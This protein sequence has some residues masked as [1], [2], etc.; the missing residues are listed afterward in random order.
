MI[1]V[2][3]DYKKLLIESLSLG[4]TLVT[5]IT[6]DGS[7]TSSSTSLAVLSPFFRDLVLSASDHSQPLVILDEFSS[8]SVELLMELLNN[9]GVIKKPLAKETIHQVL[10]LASSLGIEMSDSEVTPI[11]REFRGVKPNLIENINNK[12]MKHVK[13]EAMDIKEGFEEDVEEASSVNKD[14]CCSMCGHEATSRQKFRLHFAHKHFS[15]TLYKEAIKYDAGNK[16]CSL[17]SRPFKTTQQFNLHIGLKHRIIDEIL[18]REGVVGNT[19]QPSPSA[20]KSE[21]TNNNLREKNCQLCDKT[22]KGLGAL[23]QHYSNAHLSKEIIS[24]FAEFGDF[25]NFKCL[26]CSKS[27]RQKNGLI[28]H[29]GANH[30]LVNSLLARKGLQEL[31][32]REFKR[33]KNISPAQTSKVKVEPSSPPVMVSQEQVIISDVKP[34]NVTQPLSDLSNYYLNAFDLDVFY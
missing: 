33:G 6:S 17:C 26:L 34:L 25:E 28:I 15:K 24:N 1:L 14:L 29:L 2:S 12:Y 16:T 23:Y 18:D 13:L 3:V 7:V 8:H 10:T 19:F 30:L 20:C 9:E 21:N 31:K 5:F 22:T 11:K 27:F 32:V 4:D